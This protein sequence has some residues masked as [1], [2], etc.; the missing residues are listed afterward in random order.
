LKTP[1][2][3][4]ILVENSG[5]VNYSKV[6]RTERKGLIGNVTLGGNEFKHWEIYSL[7]MNDV[8]QL[9]FPP[10]ACE[11]PCFYRTAMQV[12]EPVTSILTLGRCIRVSY[13]LTATP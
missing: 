10:G 8:G 9:R 11:G 13:G 5:R 4:D 12:A 1:S 2:T 3:L 6:I 7:P